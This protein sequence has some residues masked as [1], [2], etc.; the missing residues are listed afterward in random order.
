[1]KL[2][3][4]GSVLNKKVATGKTA[5]QFELLPAF[6]KIT[7]WI[8]KSLSSVPNSQCRRRKQPGKAHIDIHESRDH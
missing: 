5:S 4:W 8:A 3:E 7:K 6:L 1:L 2:S